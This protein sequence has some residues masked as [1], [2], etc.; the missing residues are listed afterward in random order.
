MSKINI[1][2]VQICPKKGDKKGNLNRVKTLIEESGYKD[3]DL[4]LL[5]EFF[6]TGIDNKSF[7]ELA[8][9]ESNSETINFFSE[10]AIKYSTNIVMGTII[11]KDGEK[12]YNTSYF[13]DRHGNIAG[14]YRKMHLFNYF[15]GNE[16][17]CLSPGDEIVV[18][19]TDIGKLGMSICFDIR[20]PLLFNKLLKKGAEIIVCP[21]AWAADW[22]HTWEISNQALALQNAAYFVSC[23][24]CG[25][26]GYLLAGNSMIVDPYGNI[27]EK[28]GLQESVLYKT[29]DLNVVKELRDTFPIM[30]L[31]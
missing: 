20:F 22:V 2:L 16:G 4:I 28:M 10:I 21:A 7:I 30:N 8:E 13:I 24:G 14:K 12:L 26:A 15:G 5:P 1:L 29:I 18:L 19:E 31:E 6:N 9:E 3:I 27:V 25:D 23:T 11:E 17:E